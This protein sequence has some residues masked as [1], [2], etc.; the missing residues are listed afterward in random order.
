MFS[1][2][3]VEINLPNGARWGSFVDTHTRVVTTEA[4]SVSCSDVKEFYFINSSAALQFDTKSGEVS[5]IK[6]ITQ[7]NPLYGINSRSSHIPL[8]IF[9]NLVITNISEFDSSLHLEEL[10][11]SMDVRHSL[12][13]YAEEVIPPPHRNS[14]PSV[15]LRKRLV[16]WVIGDWSLFDV[17][18]FV[19]CTYLSFKFTIGSLIFY[20]RIKY[21]G[22]LPNFPSLFAKSLP[23]SNENP[24][25]ESFSR[26][27]LHSQ[28]HHGSLI[29]IPENVV[30]ASSQNN[31]LNNIVLQ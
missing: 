28:K 26:S 4:Q 17:W 31:N 19:C 3:R 10:W 22:L 21:P 24:L 25:S 5:D 2:P 29:I 16:D 20:V 30:E 7:A 1:K 11:T 15:D 23:S 9:H 8:T 6:G 12:E 13:G 14:A 27:P 18:I